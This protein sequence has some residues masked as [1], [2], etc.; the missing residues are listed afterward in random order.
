MQRTVLYCLMGMSLMACMEHE[1]GNTK[2]VSSQ[3]STKA[4]ANTAIS[5]AENTAAA[6]VPEPPAMTTPETPA[7]PTVT[8]PAEIGSRLSADEVSTL[9]ALHNQTRADV[10]V[11][12]VTW[13]SD[14]A[15]YMQG[16]LDKLAA[17][18][19][20]LQHNPDRIARKYG[21][22]LFIGTKGFFGVGDAAKA[23]AKEK[24]YYHG[25]SISSENF[26]K[27]GHYTQM[28]W[29]NSTEVGCAKVTCGNNV[30]VGCDYSPAGN[31]Q[32]Q[33]PY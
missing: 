26:A 16:W 19:C 28:V 25:E 5:T 3:E 22:N 12:G 6:A 32:N 33:K 15:T 7:V 18:S 1:N 10:G 11:A 31:Y 9:L 27:F 2:P 21:E 8:V 4:V 17:G 30:I 20:S 14:V 13:S 23:W 24:Q 29:R